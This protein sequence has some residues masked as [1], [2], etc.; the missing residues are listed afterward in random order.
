M[1]SLVLV[2]LFGLPLMGENFVTVETRVE[3]AAVETA[4]TEAVDAA[5]A[6]S[7]ETRSY[8]LKHKDIDRA[9]A[10]VKDAVSVEG[11]ISLQ[12]AA[13]TIVITDRPENVRSIVQLLDRFD[14]PPQMFSVEVRLIAASRSAEPGVVPEELKKVSAALAG[15]LKFNK[16]EKLGELTA[17]GKEGDSSV[18]NS[19]GVYRADFRFGGFDPSSETLRVTDLRVSRVGA[20]DANGS[21]EVTQLLKTSLNLRVGQTVILSASR[22]PGSNRALMIV[23]IA[24]K[25][26]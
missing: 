17:T 23:I 25:A 10:V 8:R 19:N 5:A 4:A 1:K 15:T 20:A 2:L 14:V 24:S 18:G 13:R 6:A 16:F 22:E 9:A 7:L 11:S 12:P 21:A 26:K 3:T